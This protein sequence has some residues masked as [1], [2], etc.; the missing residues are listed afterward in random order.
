MYDVNI[1]NTNQNTN[2]IQHDESHESHDSDED[3]LNDIHGLDHVTAGGPMDMLSDMIV[4]SMDTSDAG[5]MTVGSEGGG[6][7][8]LIK[9]S[10]SDDE[11]VTTKGQ[12]IDD[13]AD[14]LSSSDDDGIPTKV[15]R[16]FTPQQRNNNYMDDIDNVENN[17][18]EIGLEEGTGIDDDDILNQVQFMTP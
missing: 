3:I 10:L 14:D 8:N 11:I 2:E 13:D 16:G 18:D 7:G 15:T 12:F 9:E 6:I 1:V 4:G 5:I 17:N